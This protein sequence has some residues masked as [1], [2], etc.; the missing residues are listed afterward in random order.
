MHTMAQRWTA[1]LFCALLAGTAQAAVAGKAEIAE[2]AAAPVRALLRGVVDGLQVSASSQGADVALPA[3]ALSMAP[4]LQTL[5]RIPPRMTVWVD[6]LS[7]GVFVKA[8]P[9]TLVI[10]GTQQVYVARRPVAAGELLDAGAVQLQVMELSRM[11]GA[12]LHLPDLATAPLRARSALQAGEAV[13][14]RHVAQQLVLR[15]DP[16]RLVASMDGIMIEA[17]ATAQQE[18]VLGSRIYVRP[19]HGGDLIQ[20]T[21]QAAGVVRMGPP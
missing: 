20:A 19:A 15:G 3:G 9:V 5:E 8:V 11:G 13:L 4:R 10:S 16:V 18:G 14:R 1:L 6:V 12:E 17:A 7:N 2:A 21:V